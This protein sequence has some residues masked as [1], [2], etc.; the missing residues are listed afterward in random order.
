MRLTLN[1]C[2]ALLILLLMMASTLGRA[3]EIEQGATMVAH[4]VSQR[5]SLELREKVFQGQVFSQALSAWQ[6]S[7]ETDFSNLLRRLAK[8]S[9]F[10]QYHSIGNIIILSGE[11]G[12][13]SLL[14][15]LERINFDAYQGLLSVMPA[16]PFAFHTSSS[17]PLYTHLVNEFKG[18]SPQRLAWLPSSSLLLM[19]IQSDNQRSQQIYF[20]AM[21]I[22]SFQQQL[23]NNLI[24]AGWERSN[25]T[26]FGL[27]LWSK[28]G[29]Q[30][31]LYYSAQAEGTALYVLS[32]DLSKDSYEI[33]D[34]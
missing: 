21:D 12:K 33:T 8:Q 25:S 6:V 14:L 34:Q 2:R 11:L 9:V 20:D 18:L 19:N 23:E 32:D 16:I 17:A 26:E 22:A 4:E 28:Q 5:L 15:Q 27:S 31:R 3:S 10:Q 1:D 29:R 30:V 7:S 13:Y 24:L